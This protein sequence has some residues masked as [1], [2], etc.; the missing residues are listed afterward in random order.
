MTTALVKFV[1]GEFLRTMKAEMRVVSQRTRDAAHM[2]SKGGGA[3][4]AQTIQDNIGVPETAI[5]SGYWPIGSEID[6]MPALLAHAKQGGTI[7]LPIVVEAGAPL[8]FREWRVGDE[9]DKGPFGIAEPKSSA[10]V[11]FPDILL[12]PMLAFDRSGFRLGYGGGFYDRTL[13]ALRAKKKI[14]TI[15]VAY[16]AQEVPETPHGPMDE[17]LDLI[18]TDREAFM[19]DASI[20]PINEETT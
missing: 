12:T 8:A 7:A 13:Q 15:G 4:L 18:A 11:V 19:I 2:S 5:L 10:A 9:M 6:V 14:L 20:D 16:G 1:S 17:R 3:A